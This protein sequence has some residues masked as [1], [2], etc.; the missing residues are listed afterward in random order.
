M[1]SPTA[2]LLELLELLQSRPLVTGE[3]IARRLGTDRRTVRRDVAALQAIGIPVEGFRGLGGGYTLRPG[4]RMPP[5]MLTADEAVAVVLGLAAARRTGLGELEAVAEAER[6]IGRV[7]PEPLAR[8]VAALRDAVSFT[9]PGGDGDP[10]ATETSLVL[11]EAVALR[12]RTAFGYVAAGGERTEREVSPHGLVVHRGR[13][14][15]AAHDHGR[16]ADRTFRVDRVRRPRLLDAPARPPDDPDVLARVS[17]SLARVPWGVDAEV[18]LDL[19]LDDAARRIP[20]TLAELS[21][22]GDRTLLVLRAE[23]LQWAVSVV[24][25]LGCGVLVRRP[26][27]LRTALR[28][29][30]ER[31]AHC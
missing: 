17:R 12:V 29:H 23:S 6:K 14:Y 30:A 8:R 27:E 18:L 28:A 7:L 4:F 26:D 21:A 2:R 22:E 9:G 11:A 24:A 31:L 10:P 15:L 19:P 5:L 20:P 16:G 1:S 25:G 3:E 13:W